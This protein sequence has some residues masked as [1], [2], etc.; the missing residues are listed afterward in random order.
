MLCLNRLH[1]F[2]RTVAAALLL[3][4]ATSC[5]TSDEL[6]RFSEV[7]TSE[8]RRLHEPALRCR[9]E[10]PLAKFET[11]LAFTKHEIQRGKVL[12]AERHMAIAKESLS[13][14]QEALDP[15][16][17]CFNPY[18]DS[19]G[20]GINDNVDNC[21]TLPNPDQRDLDADKFGDACDPDMDGDGIPNQPDNC[22]AV[23][24]N[25][26]R[27]TDLN[28]IGDACSDDRDGDG[29]KDAVDRC[30][31]QPE[32]IDTFEDT[33]GCPDLDN[34]QD[35]VADASDKCA[36]QAEDKDGF[37]DGDGCPELD[38]DKDGIV[39]TSDK[40]PNEAEDQDGFEDGDGCP[41]PDNDKDGIADAADRCPLQAGPVAESGCPPA[42]RDGDGIADEVD[43]CP[44]K[45]ETFNGKEDGDGCPDGTETVVVTASA[46]EIRE[47]VF[48][49]LGNDAIEAKSFVLLNTVATVLQRNAQL[50]SV[51]VEGHTDDLGDPDANVALA[52]R[53]AAAVVTYLVGK[54][55][56]ADR[57]RA[58]GFGAL[59]PLC[60]ELASLQR[61]AKKNQAR[62]E[63]C[64]EQNRRVQ[65]KVLE[66]DGKPITDPAAPAAATPPPPTPPR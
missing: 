19:D 4:S 50:T 11:H 9:I 36:A 26:Q 45:K 32:D 16:P 55:V 56:S 43:A 23:A 44:D 25:D 49:G 22:P 34:D 54:A 24:N 7:G 28:G 12:D 51:L 21:P 14:L 41:E 59:Q 64:R 46:I 57:L 15:R 42:D 63:R 38:N 8:A 61:D 52:Q 35:G 17:E 66:R 48:F 39:D 20:D 31:D 62:I 10:E 29:I 13:E 6:R 37:A 2:L 40:C 58:R 53:R 3:L 33:D 65:F 27:D 47:R 5:A 18:K 30:P 1:H 60:G